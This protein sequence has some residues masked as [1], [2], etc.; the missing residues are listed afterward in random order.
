MSSSA[1][2]AEGHP[3]HEEPEAPS[4][5]QE[6]FSR[7][8]EHPLGAAPAEASLAAEPESCTGTV[9]VRLDLAYDGSPFR[10]W[11]KQPG[12]R[13]VEGALEEALELV[14]RTRVRLTV[15][16]RT[17]A[18][19]HADHQVVHLDLARE[20]W[21]ALA[22][23]QG[24]DSPE[25]ALVRKTNGAL[26]RVLAASQRQGKARGAEPAGDSPVGAVVVF[27]AAR[28]PVEFDARFS[29][30]S[31]RYRYRI[32]DGL[33]RHAPRTRRYSYWTPVPLDL[34]LLNT[35]AGNLLGLHDFL[36]FCRPRE[37]ATTIRDLQELS[38]RRGPEG[39]VEAT[40]RADAFCHNMV[41]ALVGACLAVGE[42]KRDL[43]WLQG[44]LASPA[45]D[46][47]IRLAPPQ[48]LVLEEVL[49]PGLDQAASRARATRAR[50]DLT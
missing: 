45:R 49:Y 42:G 41:R 35:A 16:G 26:S 23:R 38:F 31:R 17:D 32:A 22:G 37:G 15:A 44:R 3:S 27:R 14:L 46:S 20:R 40:V 50:R 25:Q 8:T 13:T 6:A 19:V 5:P 12:C 30:L 7:P 11:A 10:G 4:T 47:S 18:G 29:A 39:L 21:L 33:Q 28:V 1:Q 9:R 34:E 43:P 24:A 48:G 36:S 2:P